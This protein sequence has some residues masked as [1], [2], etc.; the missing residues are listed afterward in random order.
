MTE[1]FVKPNLLDKSH[2]FPTFVYFTFAYHLCSKFLTSHYF[3]EHVNFS[4]ASLA[5][6]ATN[7]ILPLDPSSLLASAIELHQ[8]VEV[9]GF[10]LI[11]YHLGDA[12]GITGP[13]IFV[14][15]DG[16]CY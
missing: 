6:E 10:V 12:L 15:N 13:F 7:L 4:R 2:A 1:L 5:Q 8:L 3:L 11:G 16:K 9:T 14:K